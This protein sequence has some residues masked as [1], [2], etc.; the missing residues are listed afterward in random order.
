MG[1]FSDWVSPPYEDDVFGLGS[2][3]V[4]IR[5][6]QATETKGI[7]FFF[8]LFAFSRAAPVAHGGSQ[9]RGP[10]GATAA[11]LHLSHSN[12]G[13]DLCLQTTLQLTATPDP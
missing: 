12:T 3:L 9:A 2:R 4:R 8:C 13:S 10:I 5:W 11:G 7:F 1:V 6:V